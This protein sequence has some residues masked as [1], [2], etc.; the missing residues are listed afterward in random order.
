MKKQHRNL[1]ILGIVIFFQ[2]LL[3]GQTIK[4]IVSDCSNDEPLTAVTLTS[5]GKSITT[6]KEKGQYEFR[7]NNSIDTIAFIKKGYTSLYKDKNEILFDSLVCLNKTNTLTLNFIDGS[8]NAKIEKASIT[9]NNRKYEYTGKPITIEYTK[10]SDLINVE[11]KGYERN[12]FSVTFGISHNIIS[13]FPFN[14][15]NLFC[16]RYTN[17]SDLNTGQLFNPGEHIISGGFDFVVDPLSNQSSALEVNEMLLLRGKISTSFNSPNTGLSFNFQDKYPASLIINGDTINIDPSQINPQKYGIHSVGNLQLQIIENNLT[18]MDLWKIIGNVN[19]ISIHT[20]GYLD[21]FCLTNPNQSSISG[22]VTDCATGLPIIGANVIITGTTTGTITDMDGAFSV[23]V[24]GSANSITVTHPG[25]TSQSVNIVLAGGVM[26]ICL[27]PILS[28]IKGFVTDCATGLPIPGATVVNNTTTF[29]TTTDNTG[30]FQSNVNVGAASNNYTVSAPGYTSQTFTITASNYYVNL[31]FCLNLTCKL[32]THFIVKSTCNG[33]ILTFDG[34]TTID[35]ATTYKWSYLGPGGSTVILSQGTGLPPVQNVPINTTGMYTFY[36]E[37]DDGTCID[38]WKEKI[39]LYAPLTAT[40]IT[41]PIFCRNDGTIK[42]TISGGLG[43]YNI[44]IKG[45]TGTATIFSNTYIINNASARPYLIA[46]TDSRGCTYTFSV[47][48]QYVGPQGDTLCASFGGCVL[49]ITTRFKFRIFKN[50]YNLTNQFQ[51]QL[52]NFTTNTTYFPFLP[53]VFDSYHFTQPIPNVIAGHKYGIIYQYPLADG[54]LCRD[55]F[56][57][58]VP[59]PKIVETIKIYGENGVEITSLNPRCHDDQNVRFS[60]KS[61]IDQSGLCFTNPTLKK[62]TIIFNGVTYSNVNHGF[63]MSTPLGSYPNPVPYTIIYDAAGANCTKSGVVNIPTASSLQVAITTQDVSCHGEVNGSATVTTV[64]G[65]GSRIYSFYLILGGGSGLIQSSMQNSIYNLP[66]GDYKVYVSDGTIQC[67]GSGVAYTFTIHEPLALDVP[68]IDMDVT[69]CGLSASIDDNLEGPFTFRWF[70]YNIISS[71]PQIGTVDLATEV[72]IYIDASVAASGATVTSVIPQSV[73]ILVDNFYAVEVIDANGCK[74]KSGYYRENQPGPNRIYNLC[75]RWTKPSLDPITQ[76]ERPVQT[77]SPSIVATQKANSL[78]NKAEKCVQEKLEAIK[79]DLEYYCTISDSIQDVLEYSYNGSAYQYTL[80]YYDRAGNLVRTVAPKG[81][82]ATYTDRSPQNYKHKFTTE[83]AYNSVSNLIHQQSPDGGETDFIYNAIGQIRFSQNSKQ[84]DQI[85]NP[86]LKTRYSYTKYDNIGRIVE[87]GESMLNNQL[88]NTLD[89]VANLALGVNFPTFDLSQQTKTTYSLASDMSI[90]NQ[91]QR[92]LDN[93]V[94]YA[95]RINL[96]GDTVRIHYSYD[97]HG[98]VEWLVQEVPGL[99]TSWV[100]Y[101]YDL[102]S[103][104]V[105]TVVYNKTKPDQ[106]YHSYAYDEDNRLTSVMTSTDSVVWHRDASYEYY[107]HGPLAS[108]IMGQDSLQKVDYA[109]TLHG[110]LKSINEININNTDVLGNEMANIPKDVFGHSLQYYKGDF[111]K[112]G[113]IFH[114]DATSGFMGSQS[115]Y[116]GNISNYLYKN[117]LASVTDPLASV[118]YLVQQF[119]YDKLNRLRSSLFTGKTEYQSAYEYD[120][121]GNITWLL[122]NGHMNAAVEMDKFTYQYLQDKNQL[123]QVIDGASN[124]GNP[125]YTNDIKFGQ[126]ANNYHYDAIG[127]LRKDEQ[128]D[129]NAI[130]WTID[131]KIAGID[132]LNGPDL[133]FIYSPT[134]ERIVKK[135]DDTLRQIYIR[136]ASGNELAMKHRKDDIPAGTFTKL[137]KE[138]NIYGSDRLGIFN[139]VNVLTDTIRYIGQRKYEIKDHL[140]NVKIVIQD[141]LTPGNDV[142]LIHLSEVYPFGMAMMGR[143]FSK[144]S[145]RWGFNKG[146]EKDNEISG[147]GNHY[148]TL[149]RSYN[150]RLGLWLNT[151]PEEESYPEVSPYCSMDNNPIRNND[152]D[153]GDWWDQV[154]GATIGVATNIVPGS[155]VIR[156]LYTPTDANDYND[157]LEATDK[158]AMVAGTAGVLTGGGMMGTGGTMVI[159]GGAV[160]LTGVGAVAGGPVAAAGGIIATEG[161]VIVAGGGILMTNSNNNQ[162]AGYNYGKSKQ[163]TTNSNQVRRKVTKSYPTRK[164]ALEAR[165]KQNPIRPGQKQVTN[166]KRNKSGEG[167]KFK[168]DKG[169]QTPHVHDKNHNNKSKPNVHY[170]IGTKKIKPG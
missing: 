58:I 13:L 103:G 124:D 132:K 102:I 125:S 43:P 52:K 34:P 6:T 72:M 121:N 85:E 163:Q 33:A 64:G 70:R 162:N 47:S 15:I 156:N 116:N 86:P 38:S 133:T 113:S 94:S 53:K 84:K 75:I 77:T 36:L 127:N 149:Y 83:Y 98:N 104:K 10:E 2:S 143:E 80:Y 161:A 49:G 119:Q 153:G 91:G 136:D 158:V 22:I 131:G 19:S 141:S 48:M 139:Y 164:A 100:H 168:T 157:A 117:R 112:P 120:A 128:E 3:F 154:V 151:D 155:T 118:P 115:L 54:S 59:P 56:Y 144:E 150:S 60:I 81:V 1:Y 97:P 114:N 142:S 29:S 170:R 167:N 140:G 107:L 24:S 96:S 20:L 146:S 37:Q 63:T 99:D 93:R 129:I 87:V 76:P 95:E 28:A 62:F 45:G 106:F 82:D 166:Q 92:Y 148:T 159:A 169:K 101:T 9:L 78:Q 68:T 108:T 30:F 122:R 26:N 25:Y 147:Q 5:K 165:P 66:A 71:G 21:N 41:T 134:G 73:P 65:N 23:L 18:D 42:I 57:Y 160:S 105:K 111:Q 44:A 67:N 145:Y 35:P 123:H 61:I 14:F 27:N 46:I 109:Y 152:P 8:T 17:F 89:N 40:Y 7:F 12:S 90:G 50:S 4:G 137:S 88:F 74:K 39:M 130:S 51:Y 79:M 16:Q 110:W 55:T 11:S 138:A 135:V 31:N 32:K 69:N 126:N